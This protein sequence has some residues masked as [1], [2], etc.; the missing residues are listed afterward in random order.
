MIKL[1]KI[2]EWHFIVLF[3][4]IASIYFLPLYQGK[5]LHQGDIVQT[6]GTFKEIEEYRKKDAKEIEWTN[7]IFGGMPTQAL[8][9]KRAIADYINYIVLFPTKA[10]PHLVYVLFLFMLFYFIFIKY[11]LNI[12]SWIAA[13]AAM[14]FTFS[15]YHIQ[16]IE[17]GHMWKV[18]SIMYVPL[19][20]TGLFFIIRKNKI[21]WGLV[22]V[23]IGSALNLNANH[24]QMTYYLGLSLGVFWIVELYFSW[25]KK[26]IKKAVKN[27]LLF[28]AAFVLGVATNFV[29]I[30]D[31]QDYAKYSN[32][33]QSE[34][35]HKKGSSVGTDIDYAF[36]W[37][38]EKLEL[39]DLAFPH[40]LGGGS[41]TELSKESP[42]YKDLIQKGLS[43]KSAE[44]FVKNTPTYWGEQPFVSGANYVGIF[45]ILLFFFVLRYIEPKIRIWLLVSI[46]FS[47]ALSLGNH[48][49]WLN[50]WIF[51]NLPFYN[52]FRA[53]SSIL[54]VTQWLFPLGAFYGLHKYINS[55]ETKEQKTKWIKKYSIWA[56]G[57]ILFIWLAMITNATFMG[58]PSDS[59]FEQNQILQAL[60]DSRKSL[61][62]KDILFALFILVATMA[63]LL[64]FEKKNKLKVYLI[65]LA[66]VSIDLFVTDN[67]FM[68]HDTFV[69]PRSVKQSIQITPLEKELISRDKS[70]YRVMNTTRNV[71]SDGVSPGFYKSVGGYFA[72]KMRRYQEMWDKYMNTNSKGFKNVV[73]MLNTKYFIFGGQKKQHSYTINKD[74]LG[75]AWFV[76]TLA[77]VKSP[78]E[79]LNSI[80]EIDPKKTAIFDTSKFATLKAATYPVDSQSM[81]RLSNYHPENMLY[82]YKRNNDGFAVFSEVYHPYWRAY[83][84]DTEVPI[85]QVD[86]L[87]RGVE[88]PKG[89]GKLEMKYIVPHKVWT[90]SIEYISMIIILA[91]IGV[92]IYLDRKKKKKVKVS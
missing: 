41:N 39:L 63:T 24:Y 17:A 40:I 35:S 53:V 47:M 10:V 85:Y 32:R 71:M 86:W 2:K 77:E 88:I 31:V 84:N 80:G 75:H 38:F 46:A 4:A 56:G 87:L 16:I 50:N 37:S 45:T 74:A 18:R 79:E 66:L 73:N 29:K 27:L 58:N 22:I 54:V 30:Y 5:V 64:Y 34:L 44:Q 52:K 89:S 8:S 15:S 9:P 76:D 48:L 36:S 28:G 60:I 12:N 59:Y 3:F 19:I 72:A 68:D 43:P 90:K 55:E 78:S 13:I 6:R 82:E 83:I 92:A 70:Y 23:A 25:K 14:A 42:L 62:N 26:E 61:F 20:L 51:N 69:T 49:A 65:F 11:A 67:E 91:I 57:T 7:Q 21:W 1:E 33:G 81:I